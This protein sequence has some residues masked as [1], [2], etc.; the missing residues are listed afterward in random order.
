MKLVPVKN[1]IGQ[2]VAL[3]GLLK[4]RTPEQSISHKTMPTF[5]EH[6]E[7]VRS[8]PYYAWYIIHDDDRQII[9]TV[10]LTK[11]REIGVSIFEHRRGHGFG[12]EAVL[13]LMETHPGKFLANINPKN[14]PSIR[15][16]EKLGFKHIQNTYEI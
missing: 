6:C 16:F 4:E 15:F 11:G 8:D 9:G 7:F 1:T 12:T 2:L 3:Y 10:Y 14:G 5:H 13:K